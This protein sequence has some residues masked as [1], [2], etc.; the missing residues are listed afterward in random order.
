M[1]TYT[2]RHV[3]TYAYA[4]PVAFGDHRAI[5]RPRESF[6]QRVIAWDLRVDP[7]PTDLNWSEDPS[8]NLV[9]LA[10]FGRRARSLRFEFTAT[11]EQAALDPASVRIHDHARTAPFS[12]GAEQMPDLSRFVERQHP[13]PDHAVDR[14]VRAVLA[15]V[16]GSETWPFLVRLNDAIRRDFAYLRRDDPGIQVPAET[17]RLRRGS[18]RDFAVLMSEAVRA[19]G[20]AA[21]FLSGYLHVPS[22]ATRD[23]GGNTHA[24]LQVYV[25]GAGW[26]DFDPTSGTV[27][28]RGLIRVAAVR[29]PSG[30]APL[31]GSFIGFPSDYGG[32][33]VGVD[34]R[35]LDRT[36]GPQPA[37][38]A[39]PVRPA[40]SRAVVGAGRTG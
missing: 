8:G 40:L 32:M 22:S 10:R 9:A 5:F 11:V 36:E 15:D 29:D 4:S 25:P 7:V 24:W 26:I 12:Y 20:F 17:L 3:T 33:E 28:N 30:A 6:D 2:V 31:S 27:G 35:L 13:D 19:L 39:A 38:E 23:A 1:S 14:W 16:P 21:R 37:A 18:C 34:V